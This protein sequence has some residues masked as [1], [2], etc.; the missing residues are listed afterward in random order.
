MARLTA[1]WG[2]GVFVCTIEENKLSQCNIKVDAI[3]ENK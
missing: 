1:I 2:V 3:K